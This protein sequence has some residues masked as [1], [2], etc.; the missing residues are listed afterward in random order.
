VEYFIT[1]YGY[2]AVILGTFLEG[3]TIL[4]L[5]GF[6]AH[7]GYLNIYYVIASAFIGS[8]AGDQ[9]YF[10]IGRRKGAA[11]L[12]KRRAW[13]GHVER[14]KRLMEKH[15]TLAILLFRFLY[16]LRT[17]APFAIG[18]GGTPVWKFLL[19]NFISAV[20]WSVAIGMLGYFFGHTVEVFIGEIKRIELLIIGV[21][22]IASAVYV[23][24]II[25]GKRRR[26]A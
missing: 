8:F 16:G 18:M 13:R 2:A 9:L 21:F 25:A 14:F 7:H 6:L 23:F 19:L 17:V 10:M 26:Q 1:Q 11:F 15:Y 12:E 4:V 20:L 24:R 5:G 3:E 22:A